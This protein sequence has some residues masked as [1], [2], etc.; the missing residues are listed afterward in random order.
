LGAKKLR[1]YNYS[2]RRWKWDQLQKE[3]STSPKKSEDP[4]KSKVRKKIILNAKEE[5]AGELK[6]DRREQ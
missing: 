3:P 5:Q 1:G 6:G 4:L 2:K